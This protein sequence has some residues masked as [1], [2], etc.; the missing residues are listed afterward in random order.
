MLFTGT[1]KRC[2]VNVLFFCKRV[3]LPGGGGAMAWT[4]SSQITAEET[5]RIYSL[6][7]PQK[8]RPIGLLLQRHA[9]AVPGD[10]EQRRGEDRLAGDSQHQKRYPAPTPI[11]SLKLAGL[12][13]KLV[14][15]RRYSSEKRR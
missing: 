8:L 12:E 7:F 11:T 15:N 6:S 14:H 2:G 13:A 3:N 1:T 4:G 10:H 9:A 5:S